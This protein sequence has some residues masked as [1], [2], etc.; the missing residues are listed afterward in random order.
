MESMLFH[1]TDAYGHTLCD[2]MM[3]PFEDLYWIKKT[4]LCEIQY[5]QLILY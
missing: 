4:F 5:G 1:I 2:P 3:I